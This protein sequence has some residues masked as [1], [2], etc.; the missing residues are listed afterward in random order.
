MDEHHPAIMINGNYQ[1]II[2]QQNRE[3]LI[4]ITCVA[5]L[6]LLLVVALIYIYRQMKALSIAKKGLQEV[7]ERLFSL[8]EELEEVNRHLRST[9]LELQS[10]ISLKK[11]ISPVSLNCVLYM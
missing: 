1:D 10:P 7:N 9:N 6:A 8:N 5:L 4:Y 3:L 2:K 11:P